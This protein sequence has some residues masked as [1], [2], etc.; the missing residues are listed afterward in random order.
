MGLK[1]FTLVELL[2]VIAIIGVLSVIA[3]TSYRLYTVRAHVAEGI[4]IVTSAKF[5]IYEYRYH[6]GQWPAN[7]SSA[8][9]PLASSIT[10]NAVRSV[11]IN[12]GIITITYRTQVGSRQTIVFSPTIDNIGPVEWQCNTGSTVPA[13]YRPQNCR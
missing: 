7:N 12:N 2:I 13:K 10:G 5:A 9:L 3:L 6:F 11:A 1:G 4:S 8:Q